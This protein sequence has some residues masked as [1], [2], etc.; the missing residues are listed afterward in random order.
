M[1][2]TLRASTR[3]IHAS[4]RYVWDVL[5]DP[6]QHH[7]FDATGMV[8]APASSPPAGVGDVFRMNMMWRDGQRVEYY[9]SDNHV[10]AWEPFSR[11]AWATA[12]PGGEP[13]GWT[14]NYEIANHGRGQTAVGLTYDWTDTPQ[15]NINRFGVPLVSENDLARSLVLLASA[16]TDRIA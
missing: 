8:I 14:W 3:T 1:T 16:L 10:T 9:Q 12:L 11:I 4:V 2:N 15:A 6:R 5:S 13:L 7:R